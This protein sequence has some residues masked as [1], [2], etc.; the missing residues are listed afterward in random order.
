MFKKKSSCRSL[1]KAKVRLD[2]IQAIK[3]DLDLGTGFSAKGYQQKIAGLQQKISAYNLTLSNVD[4][5]RSQ[6]VAAEKDLADYSERMLLGVAAQFGKN[7]YEYE[8]AGGVRKS[9]RKRPSRK[10]TAAV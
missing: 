1:E 10:Q 4:E 9:E 2:G 7:S 5:L 3:A 8:K 6:I